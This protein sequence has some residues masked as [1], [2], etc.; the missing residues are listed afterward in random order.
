MIDHVSIVR[1]LIDVLGGKQDLL[2]KELGVTQ[3][4]VSRWLRKGSKIQ[5]EH[6]D[7]LMALAEERGL[8]NPDPFAGAQ[9]KKTSIQDSIPEIDL[10][11]GLGGGG[12][13]T[14]KNTANKGGIVFSKESVRD[15]WR[16]PDWILG[17]MNAKP[18]HI[19]AFPVQGDSMEPTLNDGDVVF[20]DT[21]H[22]APSPDGIYAMAD[23]FGGV[24]VKRLEVVSRPG[25]ET[26]LVSIM[27]DNPRHRARELTLPEI[28]IIGR[29]VGRFTA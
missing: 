5:A 11:A 12:L 23:E 8:I 26:V 3:P 10:T 29:Y 7:K 14:V 28:Y 25:D 24:V 4:T 16:L 20:I 9:N 2:A 17:R 1:A 22:R 15:H 19:A 21:R 13:S 27:S 18:H 6:R